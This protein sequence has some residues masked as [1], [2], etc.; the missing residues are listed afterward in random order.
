MSP[1]GALRGLLSLLPDL[2]ELLLEPVLSFVLVVHEDTAL[3]E[4]PELEI[5]RSVG[6]EVEQLLKVLPVEVH[7]A[8]L[9]LDRQQVLLFAEG[10]RVRLERDVALQVE[11]ELVVVEDRMQW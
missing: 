1:G 7:G 10:R 4:R 5:L 8:N 11:Q 9:V 6:V 2:A 3:F